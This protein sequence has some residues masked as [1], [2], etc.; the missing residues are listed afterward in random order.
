MG[1]QLFIDYTFQA[2][3]ILCLINM[4]CLSSNSSLYLPS[5]TC[6]MPT[7]PLPNPNPSPIHHTQRTRTKQ[8]TFLLV[9]YLESENHRFPGLEGLLKVILKKKSLKNS[10]ALPTDPYGNPIQRNKEAKAN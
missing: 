7:Y 2:A 3:Y 1:D 8:T 6:H 5:E 9:T 4:L 10:C